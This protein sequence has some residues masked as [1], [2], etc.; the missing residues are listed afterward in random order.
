[1]KTFSVVDKLVGQP[2]VVGLDDAQLP[3]SATSPHSPGRRPLPQRFRKDGRLHPPGRRHG[4]NQP[5]WRPF[6]K[7]HPGLGAFG[8]LLIALPYY[9]PSFDI[10]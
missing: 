5:R 8:I 9:L 3:S 2:G 10:F 4:G 1:M 7:H 6:R